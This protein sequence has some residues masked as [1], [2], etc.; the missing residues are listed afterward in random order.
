M[1]PTVVT[2]IWYVC[3][4]YR[5]W[6]PK[7]GNTGKPRTAI[8]THIYCM[9]LYIT[10]STTFLMIKSRFWLVVMWCRHTNSDAEVVGVCSYSSRAMSSSP[11]KYTR[12]S[13]QLACIL[14]I[15]AVLTLHLALFAKI[16]RIWLLLF[17]CAGESFA[18]VFR[19]IGFPFVNLALCV[20][21]EPRFHTF[22][23]SNRTFVWPGAVSAQ[24]MVECMCFLF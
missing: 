6:Q 14:F 22:P 15:Q 8:T 17:F 16:L 10:M 13:W 18:H 11:C 23:T 20:L 9:A 4:I 1:Y 7:T 3:S 2:H 12:L 24:C 21:I 5:V 19:T